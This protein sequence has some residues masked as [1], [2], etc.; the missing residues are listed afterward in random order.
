MAP[1]FQFHLPNSKN[2]FELCSKINVYEIVSA[3][4]SKRVI[5]PSLFQNKKKF[6][7]AFYLEL[8]FARLY[9]IRL[10]IQTVL[11]N[12]DKNNIAKIEIF[13]LLIFL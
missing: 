8:L 6:L 2:H 7:K 12:S 1:D 4:F 9:L 10:R 3:N 11:D 13:V 5:F